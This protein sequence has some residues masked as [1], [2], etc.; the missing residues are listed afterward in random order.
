MVPKEE[1]F[2]R[3]RTYLMAHPEEVLRFLKNALFLRY[4]SMRVAGLRSRRRAT[5]P[6]K[7]FRSK[8]CPRGFESAPP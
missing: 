8:R 4:R 1:L 5:R 6:R 2:E 3:V 7:T